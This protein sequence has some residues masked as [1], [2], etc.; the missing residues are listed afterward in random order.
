MF[1]SIFWTHDYYDL[2]H[3]NLD[4]ATKYTEFLTEFLTANYSLEDHR[5]DPGYDS[6]NDAVDKMERLSKEYN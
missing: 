3:V 1:F 5:G 6:W 4:G 2:K